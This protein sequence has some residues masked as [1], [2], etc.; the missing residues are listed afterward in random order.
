MFSKYEEYLPMDKSLSFEEIADL[1]RQMML[2]IG[3]DSDA[4]ELYEELIQTANQYSTFRS[5]WCI[6]S[7]EEKL[8]KDFSRTACHNSLIVKFNQLA[9][10]LKMQGIETRWRDILGYEEDD[11]YN[12]KRVGDFACYIVFIN[13]ICAR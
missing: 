2:S 10:Y 11:R 5:N 3:N 6:W 4:L 1:H 8:D 9:R 7:I 13:S 12:R